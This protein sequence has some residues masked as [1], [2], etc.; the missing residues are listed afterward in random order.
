MSALPHTA[1]IRRAL[2]DYMA[3]EGCS[4]CQDS[5]AHREQEKVLAKLLRVP[6]YKDGS[7]YNFPK[8]R[9]KEKKK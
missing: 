7:G 3:S 1:K 4:C 5:E 9:T 6:K 2:A 8:F